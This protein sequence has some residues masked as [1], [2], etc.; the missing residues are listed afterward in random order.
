LVIVRKLRLLGIFVELIIADSIL[1]KKKAGFFH[2]AG[3]K[4]YTVNKNIASNI[5][6]LARK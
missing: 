4:I 1:S 2:N 5:P 3:N 6:V